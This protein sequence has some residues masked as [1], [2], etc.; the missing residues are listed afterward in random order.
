[1]PS[2]APR[3]SP[4][5]RWEAE[6]ARE[7]AGRSLRVVSA[8]RNHRAGWAGVG[9]PVRKLSGL[10]LSGLPVAVWC[11]ALVGRMRGAVGTERGWSRV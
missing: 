8:G 3:G 5:G 6:G 10:R 9:W 4:R 7:P 1:M 2:G 11:L